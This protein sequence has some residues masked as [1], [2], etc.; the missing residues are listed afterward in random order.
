M[1]ERRVVKQSCSC[2][3]GASRFE[4]DGEPIGR[5]F[6]HCLIC[7]AVNKRAYADVTTFWARSVRL[8][9]DCALDFRRHRRFPGLD[10][11]MCPKCAAPVVEFMRPPPLPRVAFIPAQSFADRAALPPPRRHIFYHRRVAD[12]ADAV[13]KTSG[14]WPSEL[15]VA[16]MIFADAIGAG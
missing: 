8:A 11:G 12:V 5:F 6:C 10:R 1:A 16:G 14:Y 2:P 7:Q 13:A 15:F 3:C 9:G 4:L